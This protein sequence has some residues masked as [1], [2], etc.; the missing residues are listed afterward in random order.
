MYS[1]TRVHLLK[2]EIAEEQT[3]WLFQ[4]QAEAR[5]GLK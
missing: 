3:L 1:D 5:P 4:M 2:E